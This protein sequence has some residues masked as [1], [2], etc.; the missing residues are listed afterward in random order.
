MNTGVVIKGSPCSYW[1]KSILRVFELVP[2]LTYKSWK[3][4]SYNTRIQVLCKG[5]SNMI[6][7]FWCLNGK[8][9][10]DYC[11]RINPGIE[12]PFLEHHRTHIESSRHFFVQAL[13]ISTFHY[14]Y[15][16]MTGSFGKN[17]Q[18][19]VKV[20]LKKCSPPLYKSY[21]HLDLVSGHK[22]CVF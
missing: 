1:S 13:C 9:G 17:N 3:I 7:P 19:T 20:V 12:S 22:R 5:E 18:V 6:G 8:I 10:D 21:E 15:W 11:I 16:I 2:L 14:G 4:S